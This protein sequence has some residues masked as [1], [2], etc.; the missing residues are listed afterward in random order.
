MKARLVVAA[1]GLVLLTGC[2]KALVGKWSV[3][4]NAPDLKEAKTIIKSIEF[5]DDGVFRAD[6]MET[7]KEGLKKTA[8]KTGKY[9]FNGFQLRLDTKGGDQV[10]NAML[11]MNRTLELKRE[12]DKLKLK[13]VEQ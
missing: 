5:T 8:M 11:I 1:L 3:D 6:V 2:S 7:S 13:R 9:Q 10:W 12:G 4:T